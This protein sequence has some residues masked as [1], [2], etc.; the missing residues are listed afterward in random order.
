MHI[1]LSNSIVTHK[2]HTIKELDHVSEVHLAADYNVSVIR[3][4]RESEEQS[5][6]RSEGAVRG[7]NCLPNFVGTV[8]G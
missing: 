4:N 5:K 2:I 6:V 7:P 8:V 3:D 1:L